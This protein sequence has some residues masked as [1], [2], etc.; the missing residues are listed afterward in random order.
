M[1][2]LTSPVQPPPGYENASMDPPKVNPNQQGFPKHDFDY[3]KTQAEQAKA[4]DSNAPSIP[5]WV[6]GIVVLGFGIMVILLHRF[7]KK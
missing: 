7:R 1:K 5:I 3:Y 2:F 4:G 6:Y